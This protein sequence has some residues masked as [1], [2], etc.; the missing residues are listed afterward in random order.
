[1]KNCFVVN[2]SRLIHLKRELEMGIKVKDRERE[3]D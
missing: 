2:K 3:M 1:M